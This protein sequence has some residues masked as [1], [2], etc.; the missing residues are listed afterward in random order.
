MVVSRPAAGL[1]AHVLGYAGLQV[2]A[3]R[4]LRGRLLP[5]GG[6]TLYI[7]FITSARLVASAPAPADRPLKVLTSHV[8]GLWDGPVLFEQQSRHYGMAVELTPLGAHALFKVPMR[9]LVNIIVDLAD[10]LGRRGEHLAERLGQAPDWPARFALLDRLLFVWLSAGPEPAPAVERGWRLLRAASGSVSV[11]RL[12]EEVGVTRRYLELGF[13]E[14]IGLPPKSMARIVRFQRAVRLLTDPQAGSLAWIADTCGY[15]DQAHFSRD[16][17]G[18]AGCTPTEFRA[19]Y[20]AANT[21][22]TL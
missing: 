22:I 9:E 12:A 13:S 15:A 11:A 18:L 19:E 21:A 20:S 1:R 6:I 4:P 8:T 17:K 7:D 5:T 3:D 10:L 16:F 2:E 14:Q